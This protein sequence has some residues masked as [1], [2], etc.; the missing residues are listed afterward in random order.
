MIYYPKQLEKGGIVLISDSFSI[1]FSEADKAVRKFKPVIQVL[2][3]LLVFLIINSISTVI[4]SIFSIIFFNTSSDFREAVNQCLENGADFTPLAGSPFIQLTQIFATITGIIVVLIYL[5]KIEKRNLISAG[6]VKNKAVLKYLAGFGLGALM[7]TSS[8]LICLAASSGSLKKSP[9][10]DILFFVL[11]FLAFLIQ[12]ASEEFIFR[13]FLLV[14]MRNAL[15]KSKHKTL[16]AVVISSVVFGLAHIMN[17]GMT[18]LAMFNLIS[19]GILYALLFIRFD[20]IWICCASH[21]AWNFFQGHILGAGVSGIPSM[22]SVFLF[23]NKGSELINGGSFGFEG[24][25]AVA[26]VHTAVILLLIFL[27]SK[28]NALSSA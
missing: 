1:V 25:L 11:F 20:N 24:G 18:I 16:W 13:G 9:S 8:A 6:I 15:K 27:P 7:I 4:L 21:S 3:F 19:A 14:S 10:V 23:E 22:A 17:P 5:K 12:G 26:A 2:I 28:K